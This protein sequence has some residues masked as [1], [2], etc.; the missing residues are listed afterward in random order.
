MV[1]AVGGCHLRSDVF[2]CVERL[3]ALWWNILL[4]GAGRE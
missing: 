2:L 1:S 3:W 4:G